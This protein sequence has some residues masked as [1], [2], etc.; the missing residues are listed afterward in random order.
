RAKRDARGG[1]VRMRAAPVSASV[2]TASRRKT[3]T[4]GL[5]RFASTTR[6]TNKRQKRTIRPALRSSS[7]PERPSRRARLCSGAIHCRRIWGVPRRTRT[8]L[9]PARHA[10]FVLSSG[11][12]FFLYGASERGIIAA[13]VLHQGA[14]P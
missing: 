11:A 14:A 12:D 10:S 6:R 3:K 5:R 1:K 9:L 7:Q 8:T 4:A 2:P 13:I